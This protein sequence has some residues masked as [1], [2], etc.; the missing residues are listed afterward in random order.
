MSWTSSDNSVALVRE[1]P[2]S[3]GL[4][5]GLGVGSTSIIATLAGIQ[6]ST[7]V[8]VTAATLTAIAITPPGPSLAKGTTVQ[9]TATGIFSDGT[10]EDLTDQVNWTSSDEAIEQVGNSILTDGLVIGV[11]VGS[12]TTT[13]TLDGIR[14]STAVTVSAA[15]LTSITVT[16]TDPSIAKGTTFRRSGQT[17]DVGIQSTCSVRMNHEAHSGSRLR[18]ALV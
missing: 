4:V 2:E 14:G 18:E 3:E 5:A 13:A 15:T 9:L 17:S 11:G 16:P 10:T 6:S 8:T 7:T 1:L 12:A